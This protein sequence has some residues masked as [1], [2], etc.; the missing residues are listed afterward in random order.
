MVVTES[1]FADTPVAMLRDAHI[2]SR[3]YINKD[4]GILLDYTSIR[5]QL[6][7][8]VERRVPFGARKWAEE[9]I[10]CQ[11]SLARWNSF[12][13]EEAIAR[14]LPWTRDL[15]PFCWKP[16]TVYLNDHDRLEMEGTFSELRRGHPEIFGSN[17]QPHALS[18]T[19]T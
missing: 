7:G 13:R 14:G 2:G 8:L 17:F 1:L 9:N 19:V 5:Q 18:R 12:L 3:T 6:M 15:V 16:Y 4:T 10:S 11:A